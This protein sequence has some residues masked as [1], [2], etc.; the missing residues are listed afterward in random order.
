MLGSQCRYRSCLAFRSIFIVLTRST[1]WAQPTVLSILHCPHII[2]S[3][4]VD[5]SRQHRE[6]IFGN[7]ENQIGGATPHHFLVRSRNSPNFSSRG[8]KR[9]RWLAGTTAAKN[10]FRHFC[11][12]VRCCDEP[13]SDENEP[14]W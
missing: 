2:L 1:R 5:K 12:K 4:A 7:A 3:S 11:G 10:S 13:R 14:G 8:R 6:K 9:W